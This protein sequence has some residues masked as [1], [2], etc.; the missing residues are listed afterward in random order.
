MAEDYETVDFDEWRQFDDRAADDRTVGPARKAE[1]KGRCTNCWGPAAGLKDR[2][3]HWVRMECRLCRRAVDAEDAQREAERMQLESEDNLPRARVGRGAVYHEGAQ[4][5]LKILPYMDRDKAQF[6]QRV[7][8]RRE[9]EP[10]KNCLGRRHFPIGH[11]RVFVRSGVRIRGWAKQF[12]SR[13]VRD[14]TLGLRLRR[15]T[16]PRRRSACSRCTCSDIRSDTG[17]ASKTIECSDDGQNGHCS[18]CRDGGCVRV[19]G[20]DEGNPHDAA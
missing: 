6:E 9:A 12:A 11:C 18:G 15:T 19:R 7:A 17:N 10:K 2:D 20:W 3:G 8:A 1:T 16:D 13:N 14:L 5:V 4:F